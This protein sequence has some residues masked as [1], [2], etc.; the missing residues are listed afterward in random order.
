MTLQKTYLLPITR[1]C[2]QHLVLLQGPAAVKTRKTFLNNHSQCS[3]KCANKTSP[4]E[5]ILNV[6]FGPNIGI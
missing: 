4:V 1:S 5:D 6:G 3:A 2:G